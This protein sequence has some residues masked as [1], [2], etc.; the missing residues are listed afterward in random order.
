MADGLLLFSGSLKNSVPETPSYGTE[1]SLGVKNGFLR[2]ATR[3][4]KPSVLKTGFWGTEWKFGAKNMRSGT[5]RK[6]GA[7]KGSL[8]YGV[9]SIISKERCTGSGPF[10][11]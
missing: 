1:L 10:G 2:Y 3:F 9:Q 11:A 7:K 6:F 8:V 5:E 4:L